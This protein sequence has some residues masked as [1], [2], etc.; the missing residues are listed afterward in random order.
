MVSDEVDPVRRVNLSRNAGARVPL[1]TR[2]S[3]LRPVT[4]TLL[5]TQM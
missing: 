3:L 4:M 5:L 1:E 2:N